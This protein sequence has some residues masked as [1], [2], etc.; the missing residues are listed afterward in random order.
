MSHLQGSICVAGVG[1]GWEGDTVLKALGGP[2]GEA[3]KRPCNSGNLGSIPGLGRSPGKRNSYL[4]QYSGLENSMDC[5]AYGVAES[6]TQL[7]NFHFHLFI[8]NT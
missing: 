2:S 3:G 8:L 4:L 7:S 5:T 6:R 1:G